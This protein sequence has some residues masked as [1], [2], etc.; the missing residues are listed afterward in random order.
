MT[1]KAIKNENATT[2]KLHQALQPA[3]SEMFFAQRLVLVE[4]L[5]DVAYLQS[6]MVLSG[7][8]DAFRS[9]GVSIVPVNGKSELIR[10]SIIALGLHIPVMAIFDADGN[11][12]TKTNKVTGVQEDNPEAR[13]SHEHDNKAM[14]R[15][16]GQDENEFFPT[17]TLWSDGLVVWPSDFANTVRSEFILA[18]G[19]QGAEQF[20]AVEDAARAD[21]GCAGDLG[22]NTMYIG[23]LLTRLSAKGITSKSLDRVCDL[24]IMASGRQQTRA[25]TQVASA[26]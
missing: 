18:L 4:G 16:F 12:L 2:V 9:S 26:E 11:K 19:L 10:P 13:A 21:A 17:G 6:W 20:K 3:L 7:R 23:F 15:L 8:W 22:K 25:G 5:E 14:L 24:I 1:S